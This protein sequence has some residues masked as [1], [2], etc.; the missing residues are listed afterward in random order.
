VENQELLK[1]ALPIRQGDRS[2]NAT[3]VWERIDPRKSQLIQK[4][5]RLAG[6]RLRKEIEKAKA[7]IRYANRL[8]LNESGVETSISGMWKS[9]A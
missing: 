9:F 1:A 5:L 3:Y 6:T 8:N 4:K 2:L 7:E